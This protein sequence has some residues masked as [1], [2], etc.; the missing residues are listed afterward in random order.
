MDQSKAKNL[1]K[2]A[3][4]F[5]F[6]A[7]SVIFGVNFSTVNFFI[8]LENIEKLSN[9]AE[10]QLFWDILFHFQTL[11]Q[12][13]KFGSGQAGNNLIRGSAP[14]SGLINELADRTAIGL[15]D[16][17]CRLVGPNFLRA[18]LTDDCCLSGVELPTLF[19]S[20]KCYCEIFNRQ[21]PNKKKCLSDAAA[22]VQIGLKSI[23]KLDLLLAKCCETCD[24]DKSQFQKKKNSN[25]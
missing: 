12:K 15:N 10:I 21:P 2:M 18:A 7:F 25:L 23:I 24:G 9:Q 16:A 17:I 19:Q 3:K 1:K 11:A 14:G 8:H 20:Y 4:L 5:I 22:R 13:P 6:I